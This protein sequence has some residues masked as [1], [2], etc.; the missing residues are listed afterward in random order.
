MYVCVLV[1][2][3]GA[4]E[5]EGNI[6][7]YAFIKRNDAWFLYLSYSSSNFSAA[8][9]VIYDIYDINPDIFALEC[10]PML[11]L[12]FWVEADKI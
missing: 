1:P 12:K 2:E 10:A 5:R 7:H 3:T 4:R 11:L 8:S 6:L 9:R